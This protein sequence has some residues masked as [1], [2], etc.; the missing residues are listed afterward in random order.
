MAGDALSDAFMSS[1]FGD[2]TETVQP[3]ECSAVRQSNGKG[4]TLLG[5]LAEIE[6]S[7]E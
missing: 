1:R 2:L 5:T 6:S 4:S 3:D 7:S